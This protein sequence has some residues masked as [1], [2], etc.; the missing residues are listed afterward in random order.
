MMLQL[1][2][3]ETVMMSHL[4]VSRTKLTAPSSSQP[5]AWF[6]FHLQPLF[7]KNVPFTKIVNIL[8]SSG[9]RVLEVN[10]ESLS[11]VTHKQ[12][13]ETLRRA[14][15]HSTLIIERGLPPSQSNMLPPTPAPSPLV[16]IG[17]NGE[18]VLL[19]STQELT[20]SEPPTTTTSSDVV[21]SP[22]Q[23]EIFKGTISDAKFQTSLFF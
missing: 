11:G 6:S 18:P 10:G 22:G 16:G 5:V 9:D 8:F 13:V 1:L 15:E 19:S 4:F 7:D 3:L 20:Q 14:S 17:E 12:A 23:Y 2:L 21:T